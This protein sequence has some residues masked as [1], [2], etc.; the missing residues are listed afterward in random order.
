MKTVYV[1]I[2]RPDDLVLASSASNIMEVDDEPD[3]LHIRREINYEN[4]DI[5]ACIYFDDDGSLI[6]GNYKV[7]VF[8]DGY[9]IGSSEFSLR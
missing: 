2:I 7:E 5:D 8:T 4:M 9:Q 1:R 6:P 3:G